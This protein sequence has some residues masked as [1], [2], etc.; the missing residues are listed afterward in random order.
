M[1]TQEFMLLPTG[2]LRSLAARPL[3]W[4]NGQRDGHGKLL[5]EIKGELKCLRGADLQGQLLQP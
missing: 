2:H 5:T 1:A 4:R 3:Y